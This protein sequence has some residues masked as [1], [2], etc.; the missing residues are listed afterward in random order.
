MIGWLMPSI[1]AFSLVLAG[2]LHFLAAQTSRESLA[3]TQVL[4]KAPAVAPLQ[5]QSVLAPDRVPT[6]ATP[7]QLA[8]I[9]E[10]NTAVQARKLSECYM[11]TWMAMSGSVFD[12]KRGMAANEMRV[13]LG[14]VPGVMIVICIFQKEWDQRCSVLRKGDTVS[15]LGKVSDF[16]SQVVSLED[17]EFI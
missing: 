11:G 15:I 16:D 7:G 13:T 8:E 14:S 10:H 5:L 4:G 17:C 6:N 3:H 9:W 2:V 1:L 12:V